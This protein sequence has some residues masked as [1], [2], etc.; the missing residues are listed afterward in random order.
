MEFRLL[1]PFEVV[2]DGRD[3]IITAAKQRALL[4]I[5]LLRAGSTVPGHRLIDELWARP[6]VSARKVLQIYVSKLRQVLSDGML[7]TRP[8]GYTLRLA[9]QDVLDTPASKV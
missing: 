2:D 6:P 3:V 5:L 7:L 1:G 4:A 8:A 9:P